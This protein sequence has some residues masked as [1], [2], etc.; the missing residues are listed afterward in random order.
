MKI[1]EG[2]RAFRFALFAVALVVLGGCATSGAKFTE[3]QPTAPR[4]DPADARIYVYRTMGPGAAVQPKVNIN[5]QTVGTAVP[6]G[7]FFVD[8]KPGPYEISTTT[9]VERKLSLTLDKGETRYVRLSISMGFFVGHV[10]PELVDK[11]EAEKEIEECR[12]T[13]QVGASLSESK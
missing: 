13:G 1:L 11:A 7:F 4:L 12:Y 2:S 5:G 10:Y 6:N 3:F 8:R 9:E